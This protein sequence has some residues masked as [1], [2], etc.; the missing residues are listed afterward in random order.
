[1]A[2]ALAHAHYLGIIHRDLK[3]ANVLISSAQEVKITDFGLAKAV[4]ANLG[5]TGSGQTLGSPSYMPPEQQGGARHADERSDLYSLG[6]TLYAL[7][8]GAPPFTGTML[9]VF[10]A[11]DSPDPVVP[12]IERRPGTPPLLDL[13]LRRALEKVP[14]R[15]FTS[16]TEFD[17]VLCQAARGLGL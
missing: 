1:M 3:P 12:A 15:R 8:T 5:M 7:T 17:Q 14:A 11:L 10:K 2:S 9:Q 4:G 13:V 6:A 16:A